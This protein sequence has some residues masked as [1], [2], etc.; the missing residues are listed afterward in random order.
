[1]SRTAL[2]LLVLL[3]SAPALASRAG[4]RDRGGPSPEEVMEPPLVQRALAEASSD[5]LAALA[6]LEG[7]LAD[8]EDP[9]LKAVAGVYAGEQ[10]RLMGD[11]T[12]A[13]L[14]FLGV[15]QRSPEH[16]AAGAARLGIALI[17]HVAAPSGNTLATLELVDEQGVPDTMNADRYRV[18]ALETRDAAAKARLVRKAVAYA[19][20]DAAVGVRVRADLADALSADGSAEAQALQALEAPAG[21]DVEALRLAREA[22]YMRDFSAA[23][24]RAA[25]LERTFP[26]SD[27][28]PSGR[29]VVRHAEAGAPYD[30]GLVGVLLPLSGTYAPAGLQLK[31]AV[32]AAF[33]DAGGVR[34]VFKDTA[35]DAGKALEHL[36]DLILK[37]GVAAVIGPLL[38]E[39]AEPVAREADAAGVPLVALSRVDRLTDA[40]PWVFRGVLTLEQQVQGL[41]DRAMGTNGYQTFAIMAPE[42][43]YGRQATELFSAG[44]TARQGSVSRVVTYAPDDNDLLAEAAELKGPEGA[45]FEALFI[46]DG[47]RQV[48]LVASAL[49]YRELA[50]GTF[51]PGRGAQPIKLLG[52]DAWHHPS[53]AVQGGRYVEGSL[54][55]DA[56]DPAADEASAAFAATY[57]ERTGRTPTAMEAVVY[58]VGRLVAV[59]AKGAPANRGA[60]RDALAGAALANP[61]SGVTGFEA[62]RELN[63]RLTVFKVTSS[64]IV[65]VPADAPAP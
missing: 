37:D 13:R 20:A 21:A 18:L 57:K 41:L 6:L 10:R 43:D 58:D 11:A 14:H 40:G 52:L 50:V 1:M 17:D 25:E 56:Y 59:A 12:T 44:V 19:Q 65:P 39:E 4:G 53:L 28:V 61:V 7:Y 51:R 5:R 55:V 32:E 30:A 64:G 47:F 49:A 54:F 27:L 2:V 48:P 33:A 63:G 36:Q 35:G 62:D 31:G 9:G 46:P 29:W 22:L 16:L 60:F 26:Q 42:N 23:T 38:K 3:T 8:G 15:L 34:L 45:D 24:R